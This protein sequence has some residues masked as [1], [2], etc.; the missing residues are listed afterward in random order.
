M[1]IDPVTPIYVQEKLRGIPDALNRLKGMSA[2]QQRE[3]CHRVQLEQIRAC[4]AEKSCP[5]SDLCTIRI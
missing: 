4:H 1:E 5:S 2:P 3:I